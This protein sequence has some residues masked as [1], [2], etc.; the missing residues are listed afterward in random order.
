VH[1]VLPMYSIC[2][3]VISAR[4]ILELDLT[5]QYSQPS[6]SYRPMGKLVGRV[7]IH[8]D[9]IGSRNVANC[10]VFDLSALSNKHGFAML[11]YMRVS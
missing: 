1:L 5:G 4:D 11:L 10:H 3:A 8:T 7:R 9:L 6:E 2:A